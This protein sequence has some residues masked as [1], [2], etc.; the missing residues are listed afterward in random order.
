MR[1]RQGRASATPWTRRTAGVVVAIAL[2]FRAIRGPRL[3]GRQ[4]DREIGASRG[5]R[6]LDISAMF[7]AV[8]ASLACWCICRGHIEALDPLA[9]ASN[10]TNPLL[11][12]VELGSSP[13]AELASVGAAA[14]SS[15]I[16]TAPNQHRPSTLPTQHRPSTLPNRHRPSTLHN[17]G[18]G[19][20]TR[21]S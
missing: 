14:P 7:H 21:S 8:K 6:C 5:G 15:A 11:S 20:L 3:H 10:T 17:P 19:A 16:E 18:P 13:A 9:T 12:S 4:R 2:T 1:P